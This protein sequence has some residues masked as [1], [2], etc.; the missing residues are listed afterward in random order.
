MAKS[1]TGAAPLLLP[2][3]HKD[4]PSCTGQAGA[5]IRSANNAAWQAWNDEEEAA[6]SKFMAE[7]NDPAGGHERW[8]RSTQWHELQA[9]K[10]EALAPVGCVECDYRGRVVTPA[11]QQISEFLTIFKEDR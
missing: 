6:Y 4:C 11:G 9:R 2:P 3:L 7:A 1:R 5:A 8:L 10:P